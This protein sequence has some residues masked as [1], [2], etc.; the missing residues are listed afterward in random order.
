M[1]FAVCAIWI[2]IVLVAF[3]KGVARQKKKTTKEKKTHHVL[4]VH[5]D[6]VFGRSLAVTFFLPVADNDS[7]DAPAP[8]ELDADL[9]EMEYNDDTSHT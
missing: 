1:F 9:F 7:K 6:D 2:A 5:D 3:K 4:F 8:E